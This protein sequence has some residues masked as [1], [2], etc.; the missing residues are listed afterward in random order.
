MQLIVPLSLALAAVAVIAA[1]IDIVDDALIDVSRLPQEA[2]DDLIAIFVKRH[3]ESE[4]TLPASIADRVIDE[5]PTLQELTNATL[6]VLGLAEGFNNTLVLDDSTLLK[7]QTES[8]TSSLPP[9]TGPFGDAIGTL[10]NIVE[11]FIHLPISSPAG[12]DLTWSF[13]SR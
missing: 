6:D 12:I 11:V 13:L 4:A 5:D 1:P 9:V 3:T 8:N 10:S 7:R 2:I